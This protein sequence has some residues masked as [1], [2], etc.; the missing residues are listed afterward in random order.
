MFTTLNDILMG[1]AMTRQNVAAEV[2]IKNLV[3]KTIR[4]AKV[5]I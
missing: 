3:M 4:A 2:A 1:T 5:N